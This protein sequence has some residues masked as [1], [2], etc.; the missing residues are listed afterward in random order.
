M[1]TFTV[2]IP[3]TA[4]MSTPALF[5]LKHKQGQTLEAGVQLKE[6]GPVCMKGGK[7]EKEDNS[8]RKACQLSLIGPNTLRHYH[9][10]GTQP[11]GSTAV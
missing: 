7:E 8:E 4:H 2:G 5:S 10:Q 9:Q 3:F 6:S 11:G 1:N